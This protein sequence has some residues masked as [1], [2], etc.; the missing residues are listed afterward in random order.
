[1][2]I[3]LY[4]LTTPGSVYGIKSWCGKPPRFP[5]SFGIQKSGFA[6]R[7]R[8]VWQWLSNYVPSLV[9]CKRWPG[10]EHV[11]AKKAKGAWLT[12]KRNVNAMLNDEFA[13]LLPSSC[14]VKRDVQKL[15]QLLS[16]FGVTIE[17]YDDLREKAKTKK[18]IF[19]A[20]NIGYKTFW[21]RS[22]KKPPATTPKDVING[23]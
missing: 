7:A 6:A 14:G 13:F 2:R 10:Q 20:K 15:E 12:M 21:E 1:M 3:M 23:V 9:L 5:A 16:K 4:V 8:S 17:Q 19:P 18:E 11:A 22:S